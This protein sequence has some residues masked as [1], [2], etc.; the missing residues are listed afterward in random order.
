MPV[1]L[2]S[3]FPPFVGPSILNL[4][5]RSVNHRRGVGELKDKKTPLKQEE[6]TKGVRIAQ[7]YPVD[8]RGFLKLQRSAKVFVRGCEKFVPALAYLLCLALP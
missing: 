5:K 2:P 3:S 6:G 4:C 8:S 7:E 1:F